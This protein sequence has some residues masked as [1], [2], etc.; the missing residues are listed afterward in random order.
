MPRIEVPPGEPMS[1]VQFKAEVETASIMAALRDDE[2]T[3]ADVYAH[4]EVRAESFMLA[5][6]GP[7]VWVWFVYD[8]TGDFDHVYIEYADSEGTAIAMIPRHLWTRLRIALEVK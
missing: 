4:E 5:G 1:N 7:S 8:S 2:I 3:R 6:N